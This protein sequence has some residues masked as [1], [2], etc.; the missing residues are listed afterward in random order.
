MAKNICMVALSIYPGDP[1]IRRQAEALEAKG[2]EVDIL[3]RSVRDQEKVER[4]GNVTAY[5]IISA[6]K[7]ESM[8][9]Y[10]VYSIAFLILAFLKLQSLALHRKY[11]LIQAHNMPDY[12]VF[13]GII[14]KMMGTPLVL[15]IHD[16]TVELFE[17]K[18][19][20]EKHKLLK[21]LVKLGEKISC[22]AANEVI[23]VSETCKQRLIS[24]GVPRAKITLVL[25]SANEEV[26]KFK[27]RDF[28][29]LTNGVKLLYHGTMAHRFGIHYAVEAMKEINEK[30]PGSVL[31]LYGR[32]EE[33]YK[34][35]L[36]KIINDLNISNAVEL[37]GVIGREQIPE[38]INNSDIGIIPYPTSDYMNLALPTKAFE[39]ISSGLPII[40]SHLYDFS[41]L[42]PDD[43]VKYVSN[44]TPKDLADAA[45]HLSLNP[46]IRKKQT[47]IALSKLKGISGDVM[48]NRYLN[49]IRT[50]NGRA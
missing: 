45:I 19:P 31:I 48:K 22:M 8:I 43:S 41:L 10:V 23:T 29:K 5:R 2:Y 50:F 12:L 40:I 21:G 7:K 39:Y 17:E 32:Y 25:N 3:C 44:V 28:K 1:R 6:P 35:Y 27:N 9:G 33:G 42:F 20:S 38:V 14:Q 18:W 46:E 4:F 37:N 11:M 24:R 49:L 47:E 30:I 15:D 26:F 16:L 34:E 36:E 13:A